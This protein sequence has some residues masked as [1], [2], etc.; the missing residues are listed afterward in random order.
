[1]FRTAPALSNSRCL[2]LPSSVM[3]CPEPSMVK[4]FV[5]ISCPADWSSTMVQT[6]GLT[7]PASVDGMANPIVSFGAALLIASR[8]AQPLLL[9][10]PLPGS[11][12]VV[13]TRVA[14]RHTPELSRSNRPTPLRV[15]IPILQ[16]LRDIAFA[17]DS[18]ILF[19]PDARLAALRAVGVNLPGAFSY[20]ARRFLPVR[21]C[22]EDVKCR[23]CRPGI[24]SADGITAFQTDEPAAL[25][26]FV[27]HVRRE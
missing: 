27:Q 1:M 15:S 9:Q 21:H 7:Q 5:L 23:M 25:L 16:T 18:V 20:A 10:V 2:L 26:D 12:V 24:A 11:A 13:T 22:S 8:N 14:D 3:V 6:P 4:L 17:A 19:S